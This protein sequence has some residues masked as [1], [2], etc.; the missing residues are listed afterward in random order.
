MHFG[1]LFLEHED[2]FFLKTRFCTLHRTPATT[3]VPRG[4]PELRPVLVA[5]APSVLMHYGGGCGGGDDDD[6]GGGGDGT[7]GGSY[8][9]MNL[10][11][12]ASLSATHPT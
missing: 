5:F 11:N 6:D 2:A 12:S 4:H 7:S 1:L 9:P 3:E 8:S 10:S